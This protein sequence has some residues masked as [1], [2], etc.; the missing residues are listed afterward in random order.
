VR[1]PTLLALFAVVFVALWV[2]A[3]HYHAHTTMIEQV[4]QLT[5]AHHTDSLTSAR[6]GRVADSV[7]EQADR[8]RA[9]YRARGAVQPLVAHVTALADTLTEARHVAL[10]ATGDAGV[11]L[12]SLR[13]VITRLV[14]DGERQDS[15][16]RTVIATVSERVV[17]AGRVITEDSVALTALTASRDAERARAV[18]AERLVV[19]WRVEAARQQ[20]Q[21]LV[22]R[23]VA[24]VAAVIAS[25]ILIR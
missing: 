7:V 24:G 3:V 25:L 12:D 2:G 16:T 20:R 22:W 17:A 1:S 23:G 13:G 18:A 5:A 6:T 9:A 21:A 4:A 11:G 10:E 8:M 19:G 15:L 14:T